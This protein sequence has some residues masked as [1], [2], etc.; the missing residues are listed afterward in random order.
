MSEPWRPRRRIGAYGI[1]R[2]PAGR[3]LLVR[4]SAQSAR[5]GTWFL[6]GGGVEHGEHPAAAAIRETAEE[7]G[8]RAEVT[9]LVDVTT[10]L[11]PRPP[12]LEHTDGVIYELAV[13]G[14]TLRPE[15]DGSSDR[16]WWLAPEQVAALPVSR[17]AALALD[18]P[19][20]EP[21][22][23]LPPAPPPAAGR[24][25]V[26]RTGRGQRFA[27]YGLATDPAERVLLTLIAGGYPGAGRWHLPGG[28]TDFGEQP[29]D[30]LLREITE[31]TG[32]PGRIT[33][34]LDVTHHHNRAELGP[35]GYPVDWHGVRA[36]FRVTVPDPTRPRVLDPGG[37]TAAAGWFTFP[38]L[39]GL[40]LTDHTASV[41]AGGPAALNG[42]HRG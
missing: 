35:E 13:T 37:S 26:R 3:I 27:V 39:A 29:R 8:L 33:R 30:G 12:V 19:V 20:P 4:G 34:L 17:F 21:P 14:G 40:P 10:E 23:L 9:R 24:G 18:L 31:E 15:P 36:I 22:E 2:D 16:A 28:G 41:L 7:T 11:V 25:P 1:C 32:Q 38:E 6:P 5:P 42:G